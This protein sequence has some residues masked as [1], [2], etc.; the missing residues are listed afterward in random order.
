MSMRCDWNLERNPSHCP[1]TDMV[2]RKMNW[3]VLKS[4][5][6]LPLVASVPVRARMQA[7][8]CS[9]A[10]LMVPCDSALITAS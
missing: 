5:S 6:C 4:R 2:L 3:Y 9:Y 7:L 8:C 1:R 10:S